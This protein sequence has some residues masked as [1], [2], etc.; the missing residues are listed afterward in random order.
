MNEDKL[1]E[2]LE[3]LNFNVIEAKAYVMLVKHRELNGSQIAKKINA[4]R[5]SV[6]AALNN[7]YKRGV[8]YLIPGETNLYRAESPDTLIE[9]IKRDFEDTTST[10][11]EDL[12]ELEE[13]DYEKNYYN[14]K[15]TQNFIQKAKELLVKAQKEVYINTCIDLQL[16]KKELLEI[17][18]RGVRT[19]VFTYSPIDVSGLPVELYRHPIAKL[20]DS[21]QIDEVRLMLV[22]DLKDTLICSAKNHFEEMTGTFTENPLLANIVAEHIHHDIYLYKLKTRTHQEL[23]DSSILLHSLLEKRAEGKVSLQYQKNAEGKYE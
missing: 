19:I 16:F 6:Y 3:K 8:V 12:L 5:S 1:I 10:L 21:V 13:G 11:K 18:Q 9:K 22:V 20:D 4:S 7:L 17:A 2:K 15:G 23:I 14:L